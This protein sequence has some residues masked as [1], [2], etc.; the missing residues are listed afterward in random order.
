MSRAAPKLQ[1]RHWLGKSCAGLLLGFG[2]ALALSGLFA[3]WGP[4]GI[5]GGPGKLQFNMWLMAPIWAVVLGFVF[6]FRTSLRAWLWLSLANA[7]AFGLL[8]ASRGLLG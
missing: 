3:W 7:L 5:A 2:L 8:H 4:G 6:L 1:S